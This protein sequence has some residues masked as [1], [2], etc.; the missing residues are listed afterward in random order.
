[1]SAMARSIKVVVTGSSIGNAASPKK[2]ETPPLKPARNELARR[3]GAPFDCGS[4][5]V[6]AT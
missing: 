4:I 6:I 2:P 3:A 5:E 1:M